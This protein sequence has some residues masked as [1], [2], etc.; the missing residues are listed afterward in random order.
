[1]RL[2]GDATTYSPDDLV[3]YLANPDTLP[4]I[5]VPDL[6]NRVRELI[7][8]APGRAWQLAGQAVHLIG[9]PDSLGAVSDA[10]TRQEAHTTLLSAA[11]RM[12]VDGLPARVT[13]SQVAVQ[14][15][16][17]A[18]QLDERKSVEAFRRLDEWTRDRE[19]SALGLLNAT[20]ALSEYGGWLKDALPTVSQAARESIERCA[21]RVDEA[22]HFTGDVEGWLKLCGYRDDA[23]ARARELRTRAATTLLDVGRT[24]QAERVIMRV[25]PEDMFL[26]AL[27]MEKSGR[28]EEA[29]TLYERIGSGADA[30]RV[31]TDIVRAQFQRFERRGSVASS[32]MY[33]L[34]GDE[35]R[36]I[37]AARRAVPC[38]TCGAQV[39]RQ[40]MGS[41]GSPNSDSH[42]ERRRLAGSMSFERIATSPAVIDAA[43][44]LSGTRGTRPSSPDGR[45]RELATRRAVACPRCGVESGRQCVT[46]SGSNYSDS[47][48]ERR[49]A[50][51]AFRI[52]P[53]I[54][55]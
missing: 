2:L 4:E 40:C 33:R 14:A 34:S 47:H 27:Y 24:E 52:P 39:D 10:A 19:S 8:T 26:N 3:E 35:R 28:P 16:R 45:R 43:A 37:R 36:L 17:S 32:S 6:I 15:E 53:P 21:G 5:I 48:A 22:E 25:E 38:P 13:R 12:L 9:A 18:T 1:M 49:R 50:A 23:T 55:S 44:S 29:A 41:G 42:V 54:V 20:L 11:A 46:P 7:D 30:S 31:R 51:G